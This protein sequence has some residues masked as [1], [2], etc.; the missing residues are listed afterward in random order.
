MLALELL[1]ACILIV[2]IHRG[3]YNRGMIEMSV[4]NLLTTT[5]AAEQLGISPRRVAQLCSEG[6]LG[7]KLGDRWVISQEELR[8]FEKIPRQTGRPPLT[9]YK[10]RT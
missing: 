3:E 8:Q 1:S 10:L 7:N 4:N 2:F 6:R 5:E 9:Q